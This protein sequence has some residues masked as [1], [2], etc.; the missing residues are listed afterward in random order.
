MDLVNPSIHFDAILGRRG[1]GAKPAKTIGLPGVGI[2]PKTTGNISTILSRLENCDEMITPNCLRALY[3]LNY[4]PLS[5]KRNTFGIGGWHNHSFRSEPTHYSLVEY[6]PQAY[7]QSDL[8]MFFANFSPS[9]VGKSPDFISM[10]GGQFKSF[11]CLS[12]VLI[13]VG[14]IQTM[15]TGFNF[16]GESNLDLQYAMNLVNPV[17][18]KQ[19]V[20]L[21]QVGDLPQGQEIINFSL[22]DSLEA[23]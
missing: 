19:E 3:D 15:Q 5:T 2:S 13:F 7:L 1:S 4:T 18:S 11:C 12:K 6:T 21:Y 20:V 8:D 22:L 9:L 14:V 17:G 10:D 23:F 16:N